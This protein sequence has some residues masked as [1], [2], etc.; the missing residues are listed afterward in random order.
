L[1]TA[2]EGSSRVMSLELL[3]IAPCIDVGITGVVTYNKIRKNHRG[4]H[5]KINNP[6]KIHIDKEVEIKQ[7][8]SS[9]QSV[10]Q[11]ACASI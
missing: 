5:R 11:P 7:L 4:T 8:Y 1:I 6:P 9:T 3:Y 2:A 10:S